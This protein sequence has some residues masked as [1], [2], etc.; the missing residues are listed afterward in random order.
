MNRSL[1]IGLAVGMSLLM[2]AAIG[3]T[4]VQEETDAV[5]EFAL[6]GNPDTLDPHATSGT[7]TFQT[8]RSFYDTLVEPDRSG[9]LVP[10][11]AESWDVSEDGLT[12]TFTLR[13]DVVFHNGEELTSSDVKATFGRLVDPET[14]SPKASEFEA[15][16]AIDTPD[17]STVVLRLSTPT[18]P[19]LASI[20]SGWGA[21][22]PES[23]IESGHDFGSKPVGT[24]PFTFV[25]WV[26][27]SRIVMERNDD[28]WMEGHPNVGGVVI[29][30]IPEDAVQIQG[31]LTGQLHAID[32]VNQQ[33]LELL[34]SD[35]NVYVR[36][37]LS[38]LVMVL[39][40]NNAREPMS[41]LQFRRAVAHA[42][43]KQSVMDIAYGGGEIVG[44]F[45][46][47]SDPYYVDF[48]DLYSY[49]PDRARTVLEAGGVEIDEPL[50]MALPENFE[51]HVR[52]GEMYQE[53]L[54]EVGI[55]VELQVVD[56]STWLNDVY[57][58]GNYDFTVIGHTGKL[59]PDGRLAGYGTGE[60]Y[61]HWENEEAA[62]AI[63]KA[64]RVVDPAER[65]EL[66][67][68]ALE[69]MAREVPHVYV[70]TSYRYVAMRSNVSGFHQDAKLDTFD[71]RYVEIGE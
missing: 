18:A 35:E 23:L 12:W 40:M 65:K 71:F 57:R 21:I 61:V 52:A 62:Q 6:S 19:L 30:I 24:G 16:E 70:G 54:E 26:R 3:A 15:I 13:D 36:Q 51:P 38:A 60:S 49:D 58:G 45:M 68:R 4:G 44:T 56:W 64:R 63:R 2:V 1:R 66:Y 11:L 10:A 48:T 28:Y 41:N 31:L 32:S 25:E 47:V 22:L 39:A 9:V 69:L 5:F 50:V 67:G 20:A 29:N 17:E 37:D 53:M 43:D 8:V 46:D 27:D 42:I 14:A 55:D 7:L 59:D 33:D 34:E